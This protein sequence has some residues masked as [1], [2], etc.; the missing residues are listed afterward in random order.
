MGRSS[1][2]ARSSK[3]SLKSMI[4]A[5]HC[6]SG[7]FSRHLHV[8]V[9]ELL[10]QRDRDV[11]WGERT[12]R[13]GAPRSLLEVD[14]GH[15]ERALLPEVVDQ[16]KT[17]AQ[18]RPGIAADHQDAVPVGGLHARHRSA[19]RPAVDHEESAVELAPLE[20]REPCLRA[21]LPGHEGRQPTLE[22]SQPGVVRCALRTPRRPREAATRRPRRRRGSAS[23]SRPGSCSPPSEPQRA[24]STSAQHLLDLARVL[25]GVEDR[26]D[27]LG[28]GASAGQASYRAYLTFRPDQVVV[29]HG[30]QQPVGRAHGLGSG[31][32]VL[33]RILRLGVLG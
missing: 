3:S 1:S 2:R 6:L 25:D 33:D 28:P 7:R 4:H 27:Q 30:A 22:V 11:S 5:D 14:L 13:A 23:G 10:D 8:G 9:P 19:Q 21:L 32:E 12:A 31:D 17:V 20:R 15:A 29:V 26:V 18:A 24:S 16:A